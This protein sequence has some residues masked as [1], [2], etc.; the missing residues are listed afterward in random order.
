M[1]VGGLYWDFMLLLLLG[2][3]CQRVN[4]IIP[5]TNELPFS[6]TLVGLD[7]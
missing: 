5:K 1:E 4:D 6:C 7:K 2:Y 3:G